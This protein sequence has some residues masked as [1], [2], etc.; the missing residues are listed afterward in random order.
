MPRECVPSHISCSGAAA[1]PATCKP[2]LQT[3]LASATRI[4]DAGFGFMWLIESGGFRAVAF[5]P[6]A[7]SRCLARDRCLLW[8]S[9]G[10]GSGSDKVARRHACQGVRIRRE[11]SVPPQPGRHRQELGAPARHREGEGLT[12]RFRSTVSPF[13]REDLSEAHPQPRCSASPLASRAV[14]TVN[15]ERGSSHRP[16][17]GSRHVSHRRRARVSRPDR[18]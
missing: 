17:P 8:K 12:P 3:M 11:G 2:V 5:R 1:H 13:H 7:L 18:A 10:F 15:A 6:L 16:A 9:C 4:C 14:K